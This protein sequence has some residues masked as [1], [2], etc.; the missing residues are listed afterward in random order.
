MSPLADPSCLPHAFLSLASSLRSSSSISFHTV[1]SDCS[2]WLSPTP[3][4]NASVIAPGRVIVSA[5]ANHVVMETLP[6]SAESS[7]KKQSADNPAFWRQNPVNGFD[8]NS[9]GSSYGL[10]LAFRGCVQRVFIVENQLTGKM[11]GA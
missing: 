9:S 4:S 2:C 6:P 1:V 7:L 11:H 3:W 10:R 5:W 8:A